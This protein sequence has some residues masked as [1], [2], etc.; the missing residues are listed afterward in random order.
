MTPFSPWRQRPQKEFRPCLEVIQNSPSARLQNLAFIPDLHVFAQD[1]VDCGL[2]APAVLAKECQHVGIDAQSNLL[3]WSRPD[4]CVGKKVWPLLWN[5]GIV[6][7]LIPE[8]VNPLPVRSGSP[9][10]ILPILHDVPFSTR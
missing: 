9:F 7:V 2:V 10:R 8:C 6:N 3:L 5:V 1:R 4:D